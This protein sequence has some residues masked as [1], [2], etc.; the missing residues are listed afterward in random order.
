LINNKV[1]IIK[2][3]YKINLQIKLLSNKCINISRMLI[4]IKINYNKI[5]NKINNKIF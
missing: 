3:N 5:N 1:K 2:S 4:K